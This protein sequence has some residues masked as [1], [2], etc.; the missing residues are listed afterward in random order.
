M[1]YAKPQSNRRDEDGEL[2]DW[3]R[4]EI[5]RLKRCARQRDQADEDPFADPAVR[6]RVAELIARSN[7]A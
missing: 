3:L 2:R 6:R 1:Q 4:R 7:K 5:R